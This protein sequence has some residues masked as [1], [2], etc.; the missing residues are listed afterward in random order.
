MSDTKISVLI[1]SAS[2]LGLVADSGMYKVF[3]AVGIDVP[4]HVISAHRNVPELEAHN[5][6]SGTDVYIAAAGVAAALPGAVAANTRF[7]KVVIGVPLDEYGI[8]TCIR[9]PSGVPVLTAG[10]G[11]A[12][13]RNAAISACQIAALNSP[14]IAEKLAAHLDAEAAGRPAQLNV[15]RP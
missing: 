5:R 8:D 12:G 2:D 3:D 11:K 7:R 1:G 6:E 4:L 13:L 14:E 15:Q 9:L 10:V